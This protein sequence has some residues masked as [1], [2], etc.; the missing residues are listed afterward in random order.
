MGKALAFFITVTVMMGIVAAQFQGAQG[1]VVTTLSVA[2]SATATDRVNVANTNGFRTAGR[3]VIGT[4]IIRY[5]GK[6]AASSAACGSLGSP[7]FTGLTRGAGVSDARA[8]SAGVRVYDEVAGYLNLG[9]QYQTLQVQNELENVGR[10][11]LN[12]ITWINFIDNMLTT[13]QS[14]LTGDWEM[15]LIPWTIFTVAFTFSLF[16][17]LAGV[18]R[19][20]F[21][22]Q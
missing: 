9:H 18:V 6:G 7:C 11:T 5:T 20:V 22:R 12:P 4:E 17:A 1:G 19:T 10:I 2:L 21:L 13:G 8:H 14:F 16:L 15:V 3:I